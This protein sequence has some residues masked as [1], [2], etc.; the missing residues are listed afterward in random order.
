MSQEY[1]KS[2][3]DSKA[4]ERVSKLYMNSKNYICERCGAPGV[5][6]HHKTYITPNNIN[7]IN[8]IL[9]SDN[10][11]CLCHSCHDLEHLPVHNVAYFDDNGNMVKARKARDLAGYDKEEIEELLEKARRL[12]QQKGEGSLT[13]SDT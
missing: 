11:E 3:Y 9:N 10:L 6:C 12:A 7:D 1:S 5:I 8:I 4:W 2:F 13:A